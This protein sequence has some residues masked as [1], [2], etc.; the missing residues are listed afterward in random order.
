MSRLLPIFVILTI[1]VFPALAQIT[2]AT[3][4]GTIKDTTGAVLPGAEIVLT[5]VATGITRT[6]ISD[7]EG[8]Y[9]ASS[10]SIGT[11][12]VSAGLP[13]FQTSVRSG[14]TLTTGREAVIDFTLS[15]GEITERV[16]VTGEAALVETT[17]GSLGGLVDKQTI[18]ELPL[19]GRD[20]TD[21]ITLQPGTVTIT[22]AS[23]SNN[24]GFTQ[25]I[26]IGGARPQDNL[27]L[28]DGTEMKSTDSGVPAGVSGNF[29][30]AEATQ[31]FKI[32]TSAYSAIYGGNAGGVINVISKGGTNEFHG[33]IYEFHR[34]D[35]LDSADFRAPAVIDSNS[36]AFIGKEKAE[37]KRNQ[38]GFA[39]GGPIIENRTFFFFNYEGMRDRRGRSGTVTTFGPDAR[40]GL[41]PDGPFGPLVQHP[42]APEVIPYFALWPNPVGLEWEDLG[43]GTFRKGTTEQNPTNEDFYQGRVDHQIT[44][45]D[46]FFAR[47]TW[48]DSR[49]ADPAAFPQWQTDQYVYSRLS[50]MEWKRIQSANLLN[51]F[52]VGANRRGGDKETFQD[53]DVDPALPF[54]PLSAWRAPLGAGYVMGSISGT[55]ATTVGVSNGWA[56]NLTNRFQYIDDVVYNKGAHSYKFGVNFMRIQYNVDGPSRPAGAFSF[57]GI[58]DFLAAEPSSFR[59]DILPTQD[60]QRGLRI[61][62]WGVYFQD[63]WKVLP[64]LT[65]NLGLRYELF[66]VPREVNGKLGNL[67]DPL[68][69]T[70]VSCL[71]TEGCDWFENP[72][73]KDFMPRIGF[74]WDPF[75]DGKMALR[76]GFGIFYNHMGPETYRQAI[77]RMK[78]FLIETNIRSTSTSSV[79]FADVFDQ[80]VNNNIGT[81][82]VHI[83]PYD[84]A[85]D[86]H[87]L[88]WNL[89]IQREIMPGT[90]LMVGYAGSRGL[91]VIKNVYLQTPV[92]QRIN[93]RLVF[94]D[95][96]VGGETR[97]LLPN[98]N[99]EFRSLRLR[100]REQSGDS[101]YHSL[102]MS[103][104]RRFSNGFQTQFSYT[105]AKTMDEGSQI[106]NDL[107]GASDGFVIPYYHEPDLYQ[108]LSPFGVKHAFVNNFVIQLPFGQGRQFGGNMTGVAQHILGGWQVGGILSLISGP[109]GTYEQSDR[110]VMRTLGIGN[111]YP[112]IRAGMSPQI[113]ED[114]DQWFST[115]AFVWQGS[116]GPLARALSNSSRTSMRGPGVANF[117][118]SLNKTTNIWEEVALQ[119]RFEF[120]NLTNNPSFRLP[121]GRIFSGSGRLSSSAGRVSGTTQTMREAQIA[122]RITF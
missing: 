49:I 78:P 62:Q 20:L 32:E 30:G 12:E 1:T 59:G 44:D 53:P 86:P 90:G 85:N 19:N 17:S 121:S 71:G 115:D 93:G 79:P 120:F 28:I 10:L 104:Q 89:N 56:R 21:L 37:F 70:E 84:Y 97:D 52:R 26:S 113:L 80:V 96:P 92:A 29:M 38:F 5:N 39:V 58:E 11:Y 107:S 15:L 50:T 122:L 14:I 3:I 111:D 76:S 110:G 108:G 69:D 27:I 9:T 16:T 105:F 73:F 60:S 54:V 45:N 72:S 109:P 47:F 100:S 114:P 55:G 48:N 63:D 18:M 68:N 23:T 4:V 94:P 65:V 99:P 67:K 33:S 8:R 116:T 22:A 102:Q 51:T 57:G 87:A 101:W 36:G 6:N 118:F 43:D 103:L 35:N 88:Q 82:D 95:D 117:D 42:L 66:T 24:S 41:L 7:D 64:N 74:A 77:I 40:L 13:G 75:G 61:S 98:Q 91:N 119:I 106:N 83:F 34:N 112:D 81:G 31:E 25:K 2:S 46:S